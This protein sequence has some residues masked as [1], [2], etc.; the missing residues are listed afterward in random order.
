LESL[1]GKTCQLQIFRLQKMH[2]FE[3]HGWKKERRWLP[4]ALIVV[5][6]VFALNPAL[7]K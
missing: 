2:F 6:A 1:Q 7:E 4:T 3:E 5:S